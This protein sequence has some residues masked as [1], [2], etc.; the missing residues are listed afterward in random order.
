MEISKLST[1]VVFMVL[2]MAHFSLAQNLPQ[3]IVLA[4]N[5][6][7]AQVGVPLPPLTW[8]D[9]VAAYANQYASTRLA[10]CTLVHS[11]SPYGEN[12]AM[13]YGDFSAV[14]AVNMWVGEK[15]NYDYDSNSCKKDMCGHYTQVI[16][17]NTLQVG[18]ARL[19]CD[20]GETW[21]V[22]CNYFPPGNYDGEKPY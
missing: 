14:E 5:N 3:D 8:N 1:F 18:C 7:R 15:P 20:N 12:L 6:A 11:D 10:E 17:Q 9:T 19:K 16:W 4:H 22:S 13:G 21:F 2:A